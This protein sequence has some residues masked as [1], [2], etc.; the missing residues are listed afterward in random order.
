MVDSARLL[1]ALDSYDHVIS[2]GLRWLDEGRDMVAMADS[3]TPMPS[4][5]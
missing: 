1:A 5:W 4:G 3:P 2:E